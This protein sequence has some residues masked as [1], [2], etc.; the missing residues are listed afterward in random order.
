MVSVSVR[1]PM[2]NVS[3]VLAILKARSRNAKLT[4]KIALM[5]NQTAGEVIKRALKQHPL[6]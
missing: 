4:S 6:T 3:T 2:P 5:S 1:Q